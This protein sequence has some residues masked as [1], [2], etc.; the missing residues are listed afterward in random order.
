MRTILGTMDGNR[1]WTLINTDVSGGLALFAAFV[2]VL[3]ISRAAEE[4]LRKTL[5]LPKSPTA[6]AYVLGRLSNSELIEAPRGEFV[7]V[8]LLQRKGLDRKYRVEALAGLAKARNTE[9]F[10]ELI[11]GITELDKKGAEF[12]PV[13]VELASLLLQ[14]KPS[15]LAAKRA[16][17]ERLAAEAQLPLARQIGYAALVTAD[18]SAEKLWG[19]SES[20]SAKLVDLLLS[21]PLIRDLAIRATLFPKVEPLIHKADP[22]EVRRAAI[23][24]VTAITGHEGETFNSL[25]ALV[26]SGTEQPVAIASLQRIPRKTWPKEQAGRLVASVAAYL[27]G[28]PLDRRTDPEVINALQFAT[29]LTALLPPD[30]A[31]AA[32]KELRALG[33]TVFLVRTIPEQMLYDKTLIVVEPGAPVQIILQNDDAMQHNLV[34]VEPGATE[35]IGLAAEKM[36]PQPDA[37]LRLYVPDS[38]KVLFATKMLDGG[39]TTKLA[40]TAPTEPGE[41]PYLCTYPAHWRR[42]VGTLA[43]VHDV[44]GY[45]A[46]HA[47]IEPTATEWR[48][49]DLA[50]ELDKVATGRNLANGK[51]LFTKLACAQCHKLGPEGSNYGPDLTDVFKRYKNDRTSVVRQILE[52]SLVIADRYRNIE[53]TLKDGDT[54]LGMI[55]KEEADGVAI[56]TG[57]SEALVQ[58]L[59][60]TDIT[61]RKP[62]NSSTMPVALLNMLSKDQILDLLAYLESNGNVPA[63]AH[64]Q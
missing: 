31:K 27:K 3:P 38:P 53:F 47:A 58:T 36:L 61:E 28:V 15:E 1:R 22:V 62:Q 55:V 17:L 25:A 29:D 50:G 20:E 4:P 45:L 39:Q 33:T 23:T 11:R 46:S 13:L 41:Y 5:F 30:K 16:A 8:A 43:V 10:T 60:R 59:K 57:P 6:A 52:P 35:E 64:A 63:H 48:V 7:Y 32:G 56:Q 21:I 40:F 49:D 34:I 14:N 18:G 37:Y 26:N 9:T 19:Q 44:E 12:E 42:M 2:L 51:E 24:A 54:V